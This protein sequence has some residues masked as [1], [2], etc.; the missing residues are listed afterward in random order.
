MSD[1]D[2]EDEDVP[3]TAPEATFFPDDPA[4]EVDEDVDDDEA[5][6]RRRRT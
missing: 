6:A 5:E 4:K 3:T 2:P 1:I